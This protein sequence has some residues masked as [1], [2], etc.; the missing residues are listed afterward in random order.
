MLRRVRWFGAGAAI[1]IGASVWGQRKL[2]LVA[3]RYRPAEYGP[4][5]L[6]GS[7]IDKARTWPTEV[8]AALYE[9]RITMR[10]RE[11]ELRRGLERAAGS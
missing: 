8:R 9:G 11:A 6:A 2:K 7:A 3:A 4:A 5:R 10:Q 1:G